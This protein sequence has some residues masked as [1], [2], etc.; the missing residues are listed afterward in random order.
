MY[1]AAPRNERK[2]WADGNRVRL[3]PMSH[4]RINDVVNWLHAEHGGA[5]RWRGIA[6][7][8]VSGYRAGPFRVNAVNVGGDNYYVDV[9]L[10]DEPAAF[11]CFLIWA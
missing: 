11:H 5:N 9:L 6:G 2:T 8:G 7:L 1:Y 3:G 4:D 10:P